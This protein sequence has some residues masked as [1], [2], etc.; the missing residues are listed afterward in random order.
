MKLYCIGD[1]DTVR[2]FRLA[3]VEG[4]AVVTA[5]EA[6]NALQKAT[7]KT[8]L[9]VIAITD[10][11]AERIQ[12]QL[13]QIRFARERPLILE[14]PGATG[15]VRARKG[16]RQLVQEAVGIAIDTEKGT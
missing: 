5:A 9:A 2:G 14:I 13:D 15:R 7:A 1:E 12:A 6:M 16:L 10:D 4:E 11:I 8:D 3:G